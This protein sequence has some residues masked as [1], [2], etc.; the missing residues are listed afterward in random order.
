VNIFHDPFEVE[1]ALKEHAPLPISL[2]ILTLDLNFLGTR[3]ADVL[4]E[5]VKNSRVLKILSLQ[6]CRLVGKSV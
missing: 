1:A 4:A 3:G 6:R 2:R 5:A